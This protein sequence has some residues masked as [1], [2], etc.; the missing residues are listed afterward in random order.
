MF[1]VE[2]MCL[3]WCSSKRLNVEIAKPAALKLITGHGITFICP[4]EGGFWPIHLLAFKFR[5]YAKVAEFDNLFQLDLF[6]EHKNQHYQC[7]R[8]V[9]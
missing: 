6:P 1:E 8:T 7:Q 4:D 3:C 5:S 9:I 2:F